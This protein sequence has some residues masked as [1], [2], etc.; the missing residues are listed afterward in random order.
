MTPIDVS[1]H[2]RQRL[3]ERY[4]HVAA[5]HEPLRFEKVLSNLSNRVGMVRLDDLSGRKKGHQFYY[6]KF[7]LM[8]L[9]GSVKVY[10]IL[11]IVDENTN[12]FVTA[13]PI[14]EYKRLLNQD[15]AT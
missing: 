11:S 2:F 1:N 3:L 4:P 7:Q 6:S 12:R 14:T 15:L 13:V 9:S 5:N 8:R 10:R